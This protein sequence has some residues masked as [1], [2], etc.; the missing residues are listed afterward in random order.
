METIMISFSDFY[1]M[2]NESNGMSIPVFSRNI[3]N[4][5]K[6]IKGAN[7]LWSEIKAGESY[8]YISVRNDDSSYDRENMTSVRERTEYFRNHCTDVSKLLGISAKPSFKQNGRALEA[9]FPESVINEMEIK[10]TS[11]FYDGDIRGSIHDRIE[12]KAAK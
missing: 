9:K 12:I 11:L 10:Y 8:A 3:Y 7:P 2:I 4:A 5:L 1:H 6:K